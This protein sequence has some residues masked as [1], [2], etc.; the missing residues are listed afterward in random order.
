MCDIY[1]HKLYIFTS[2]KIH[3]FFFFFFFFFFQLITFSLPNLGSTWDDRK[4]RI[5]MLS[6][7]YLLLFRDE[8][9]SNNA[10]IYMQLFHCNNAMHNTHTCVAAVVMETPPNVMWRNVTSKF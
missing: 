1:T 4:L 10:A 6:F 7:L 8:I 2:I 5:K 3:V 9:S